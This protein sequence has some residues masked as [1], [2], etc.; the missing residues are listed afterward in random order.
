[1]GFGTLQDGPISRST[2]NTVSTAG[3]IDGDGTEIETTTFGGIE[4]ITTEEYV[5]A[6]TNLAINGQ[7]GDTSTGIVTTHNLIE[8]NVDYDRASKT[9]RRALVNPTTTTTA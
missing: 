6:F 2:N 8:S 5:D 1:M 7:V 4:E 9:I 3:K